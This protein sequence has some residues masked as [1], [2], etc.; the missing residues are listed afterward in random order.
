MR[1]EKIQFAPTPPLNPEGNR[2]GRTGNTYQYQ[3]T[4]EDFDG[5][6]I[7]YGW[8]WGEDTDIEW[9][10]YHP[11]GIP[12]TV[13]HSWQQKGTYHIQVI[14]K[15][16]HG[17]MSTWSQKQEII[18]PIESKLTEYPLIQFLTQLL[19]QHHLKKGK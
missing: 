17:H 13:N 15:D 18:M 2:I 9:T 8:D 14:A 16:I 6:R 4:S 5:D 10:P 3:T 7:S 1:A 12:I 11:P 19:N